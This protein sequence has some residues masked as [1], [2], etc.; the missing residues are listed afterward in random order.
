MSRTYRVNG[1]LLIIPALFSASIYAQASDIDEPLCSLI[2][3]RTMSDQLSEL[4]IGFSE[5]GDIECSSTPTPGIDCEVAKHIA[6]QLDGHGNGSIYLNSI[7]YKNKDYVIA[8]T[9]L[10]MAVF[11]MQSPFRK[12][13]TFQ[14][15]NIDLKEP[16]AWQN[17]SDD[18][19]CPLLLTASINAILLPEAKY[20][21]GK[22][23]GFLEID[24]NHDGEVDPTVSYYEPNS[25]R[26]EYRYP[27]LL[28]TNHDDF[29]K[30]SI[31][32]QIKNIA[33]GCYQDSGLF[34]YDD[35]YWMI[36]HSNDVS[37]PYWTEIWGFDKN[38]M[39][40]TCTAWVMPKITFVTRL[41]E[42]KLDL[43]SRAEVSIEDLQEHGFDFENDSNHLIR[44]TM[45]HGDSARMMQLKGLGA[46]YIIG[47]VGEAS[48]LFE[49]R[50]SRSN[51]D[52]IRSLINLQKWPQ[53]ILQR[54]LM[55]ATSAC[56][57]PLVNEYISAAVDVK[58]SKALL[59]STTY[60][61]PAALVKTILDAGSREEIDGALSNSVHNDKVD[62]AKLLI[63][64]RA[65]AKPYEYGAAKSVAMK[66][67]LSSY[68][69]KEE[70]EQYSQ[71]DG[72]PKGTH[73]SK[74]ILGIKLCDFNKMDS[75][76]PTSVKHYEEIKR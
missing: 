70:V 58:H 24:I 9:S 10:P 65:K 76:S 4:Y 5:S 64:S 49:A 67:L 50:G 3:E 2:A 20:E 40:H 14:S 61:C 69:T 18:K 15:S 34:S 13:C 41:E 23:Q 68:L 75:E 46:K 74:E 31:N 16:Q 35:E 57:L 28:N 47:D 12:R 53:E 26:C 22:N 32:E 63:D 73:V 25:W 52:A 72:C 17:Q 42:L 51:I 54:G 37:T 59:Y 56:S 71:P 38:K 29:A 45:E 39:R 1:L 33:G 21:V 48:F 43:Q 60:K 19:R 6:N 27:Q 30:S 8:G 62:V 7:E 66:N 55:R 36:L 11:D 44:N